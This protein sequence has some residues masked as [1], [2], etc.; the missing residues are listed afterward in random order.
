MDYASCPDEELAQR[1]RDGDALA[2]EAIVTRYS[3]QIYNFTL[4]F[5]GDPN[6]AEDASQLTFVQTFESFPRSKAEVPLRPWLF[7]VAHNKCIDLIRRRRTIALSS[8]ERDDDEQAGF[9]PPDDEPLPELVFERTELQELLQDAILTLPLRSREV[10][11]MRYLGDLTF[12][13]IGESLGI[14]EN[15]A[16]TLFQRAKVRLRAYLRK[17]M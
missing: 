2:F 16:K 1:F 14:P 17:R 7:Q 4:R 6:D 13:E 5:L 12:G 8:M 9:D 3:R 10:V 15:T 11:T